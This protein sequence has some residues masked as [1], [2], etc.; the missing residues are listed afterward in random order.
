MMGEGV[1]LPPSLIKE[2]KTMNNNT[3]LS[4]LIPSCRPNDLKQWLDSLYINCTDPSR[5]ELSLTLESELPK[6]EVARWGNVIVRIVSHGEFNINQLTEICYKQSTSPYIF[7]SGDDTICHSFGWDEIFKHHVSKY[8]DGIV[9]VYP[10]DTIFGQNLACYPCTSRLIMDSVKWPVP[11]ERYAIDDTIF[12]IVPRERRIYLSHVKMEHLHLVDNPPGTPVIKNG[13]TF[14]YPHD[15][16]AMMRDRLLYQNL[17]AERDAI[18]KKLEIQAGLYK[19]LKVVIALPTGEFARRADFYD[20]LNAIEKPEGTIIVTSHGQSPARNR[21]I[22]I[23]IALE[24]N[25]SHILFIDDDMAFRPDNLK[26]LLGHDKDIVGGLYLHRNFPHLPI[27]FDEAY[28]DGRC[29][30]TF[31]RTGTEGLI[32]VKNMG[33]GC[34]L[35][36]TEVFK[37]MPEPWI[38]LGELEKDHWSDDISFFNR[39]RGHGYEIFVDTDVVCGHIMSAIIWPHKDV[40]TG[41]WFTSYNTGSDQMFMVAQH[42]PNEEEL[43]QQIKDLVVVD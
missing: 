21:N 41:Q 32:K 38:T 25:A 26:K 15:V 42:M 30:N 37:T 24:Q 10:N 12:D 5:I 34:A 19:D 9:L 11:F 43:K 40:N 3:W 6:E 7:L 20:Y 27:M 13:K 4:L 29:K 18:R 33:L 36:K 2:E 16:P 1:D 28:S 17:Q 31:L 14:Y 22:M 23:K 35:I 39:A 8:S